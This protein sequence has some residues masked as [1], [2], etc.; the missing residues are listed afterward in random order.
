MSYRNHYYPQALK[1]QTQQALQKIASPLVGLIQEIGFLTRHSIDPKI[2]TTTGDLTG[3]HILQ[4]I[5]DPGRGAYH[6]GASDWNLNGSVIKTIGESLERYSQL[7]CTILNG[8]QNKFTNYN[9]MLANNLKLIDKSYYNYFDQTQYN[10]KLFPFDNFDDNKPLHWIELISLIDGQ[11]Y[12]VPTQLV[13][14]GYQPQRVLGE[15]WINAAVT[16]GTA[17]HAQPL[18]SLINALLELIQID[19][20][21]G[22]WY[23]DKL[24]P[25]IEFSNANVALI[26]ILRKLQANF[27]DYYTF[28]WLENSDLLGF[29]VA[30]V[31]R[32]SSNKLPKIA[33]GLGC[34]IT[35]EA[36]MYKAFLECVSVVH[37]AR[38]L[39]LQNNNQTSEVNAHFYDL[40]QN[41]K[42]YALGNHFHF[43][44]QKF[45]MKR[46]VFAE[47]LI[48]NMKMN[49]NQTV[50]A[51]INNFRQTKK[52]LLFCDL[53][54]DET[55]NFGFT[56]AR[57]WSP[58]TLSLCLPSAP[59]VKHERYQAYGGLTHV[60][61]HPYP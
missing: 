58:Q 60:Y 59:W 6:I 53:T 42:Y 17:A 48:S 20:A 2:I 11:R 18:R 28:H 44:N 50:K 21:M 39:C 35:L 33:V 8:N 56:V 36:T 10:R 9:D 15:P 5:P 13:L 24:A 38:I 27:A 3:V 49:V 46:V 45:S 19:S 23:S 22:H 57:V 40:N 12:W 16:T 14:V 54:C 55:L 7:T 51:L 1:Q 37:L 32:N 34:D 41:V 25:K 26:K 52:E 29:T 61:P 4:N 30:C 47:E 31:Y 43:I